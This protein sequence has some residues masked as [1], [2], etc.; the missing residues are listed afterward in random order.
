M[1]NNNKPTVIAENV[2]VTL[3]YELTVDGEVVDSSE[4]G[5]PIVFLQGSNQLVPGLENA[6][7]G[8]KAGESKEITVT[9]EE[10]YGEYDPDSIVE[11]ARS[12]FP[13]DF[14]LEPGVEITVHTDESDDEFED[15]MEATIVKVDKFVVTLN[16]NHPLAGKTLNFKVKVLE[17]REA[18][19]EEIEHGHVHGDHDYDDFEFE[20][21]E[22]DELED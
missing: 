22:L 12:E 10:G 15:M 21:E 20:D 14:P 8:L 5:D 9:P 18:T 6:L 3:E 2:V 7:P 17:L 19:P 1:D 11:V 4:E 13:D 16:F